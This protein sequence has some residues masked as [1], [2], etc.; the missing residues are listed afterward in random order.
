MA[1]AWTEDLS[2]GNVLIDSEHKNLIAM[3]NNLEHEIRASHRSALPHAFEQLEQ[4]LIAHFANE[5]KM[6]QAIN[7]PFN[8]NEQEHQHFLNALLLIKVA[9]IGK[10]GGWAEDAVEHYSEYLNDWLTNHVIN[11]DMLMKPALQTYSYDFNP[12]RDAN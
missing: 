5:E 1:L 4:Y 3:V 11:E 8:H 12:F 7:F 10:R 2:V 9:V 6:A